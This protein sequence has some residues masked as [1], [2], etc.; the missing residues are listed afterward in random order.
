MRR[1]HAATPFA[2]LSGKLDY[3]NRLAVALFLSAS[4]HLFVIFALHFKLPDLKKLANLPPPMEVVLVNAKSAAAPLKADALAQA[5]L[6]GGGNTDL[7]RRAK[8]PLPVMNQDQP[9]S[10]VE[11]SSRRVRE[12]EQQA[13]QLMTQLKSTTSTAP[14]Q[15]IPQPAEEKV[16][17]PNTSNLA[18]RSL[19]MARL[20]AQIS[21]DWD[22]Y[23]K[24][25]K[26]VFV[27]ARTAKYAFAQYVEDW[28]LKVERVGNLNYPEAAKQ[29]KLYGYLQLTVNIRSDGTVEGIDINRS[30]GHKVLDAAARR[31]VELAAPYAAFPDDM[32]KDTD[33]LSITRT[34][35]FTRADQLASE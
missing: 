30:S 7:E 25:P 23:Q 2:G 6:E 11:Q 13:Q 1:L 29:Q 5:N 22:S 4:L 21:R 18:Q 35:I 12:M 10:A 24:R 19:Q 15:A 26:R 17:A 33:I 16:D 31:I 14:A 8:S 34:W 27:G 32:R 28:R 9:E 20:E 3:T